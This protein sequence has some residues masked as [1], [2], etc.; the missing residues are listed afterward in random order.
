MTTNPPSLHAAA[1]VESVVCNLCGADD[2]RLIFPST[3]PYS[4][5]GQWQP[6]Q[7]TYAGYGEHL[8]VVECRRC[9]LRYS[10]P[11]FTQA[12]TLARYSA[13]EDPTY[14]EQLPGRLLTFT[15]RLEHFERYAG[16]PAGRRLLDVGAYV[17]AC[18][19]VAGERGW[20]AYGLEPSHWAVG[21]AQRMGLDVRL[22]TLRLTP[23]E[24][25]SLDVV[26][27]WDVIEHFADPRGELR[28]AAQALNPGGWV[29]VHTM[30]AQSLFARL[31]GKRWP[32]LMEMHVYYFSR[33]TLSAMLEKV[34]FEVAH[35]YAE[36]RY[37]RLNYLVTRLEPYSKRLAGLFA[38]TVGKLGVS[39]RAVPVNFGD[40]ITAYARKKA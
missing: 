15:R 32:W 37:L 13:V 20:D 29:V 7:C 17:G 31:M 21:Q 40:L 22:G 14:L 38:W 12:A 27:L 24:P 11:R 8:N 28:A 3:I 1:E 34:G 39:E 10:N 33:K 2:A 25:G 35:V 4:L 9:G 5:N 23:P 19:K 26:M 18:V 6:F 16:P 36:G 30:D